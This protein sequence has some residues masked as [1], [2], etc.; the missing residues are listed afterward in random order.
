MG[1]TQAQ[2]RDLRLA[3]EKE[4]PGQNIVFQ[5]DGFGGLAEISWL[6]KIVIQK[7]NLILLGLGAPLQDIVAVQLMKTFSDS[8]HE[9]SILTCGGFL[10]QIQFPT[11][12]PKFAYSLRVNWL[13][14]L[15]REPKRLWRRY[16]IE[17]FSAI[18]RRKW[19]KT[20]IAPLKGYQNAE[21]SRL[22]IDLLV[23]FICK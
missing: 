3:F 21:K 11:Y 23:D 2:S 4:Y 14:R 13:V 19:L 17:A 20:Q 12:Y 6:E 8:S 5:I 1:G 10:D 22:N 16:S 15:L 7:P 18:S 9:V